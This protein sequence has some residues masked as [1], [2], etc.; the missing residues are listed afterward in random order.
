MEKFPSLFPKCFI[1]K[2][3]GEPNLSTTFVFPELY[4]NRNYFLLLKQ[5][6]NK[7]NHTVPSMLSL[8]TSKVFKNFLKICSS[9]ISPFWYFG[10]AFTLYTLNKND[11]N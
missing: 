5:T 11:E 8:P 3:V 10:C 7:F 4:T 6:I 1:F 2:N 9:V